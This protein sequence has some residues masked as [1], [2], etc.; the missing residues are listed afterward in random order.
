M[1]RA[2]V[3]IP[4]Y[5]AAATIRACL[6]ALSHQT[7]PV[8]EY[9]IIVVDDGSSD[10]TAQIAEQVEGVQVVRME[11]R[12]AAAARNRGAAAASGEILLFTDADCAPASD[13]AAT[14]LAPF[15]DLAKNIVGAK[16]AYRTAQRERVA[17]FVQLEYEE[18]YARLRRY[19]LIDFIDTYSAAYRRAIFL[20]N[21]GFDESFPAASVEDQEFSFRLAR[22]GYRMVFVPQAVVEHRHPASLWAYA[23]R[24]FRIGYWKVR[25]HRRFP[26]KAWQDTHTPI[27]LKLQVALLLTALPLSLIA[28]V[29]PLT[30]IGVVLLELAFGLSVLPLTLFIA[31]RDRAVAVIAPL[32]IFVRAAALGTGL[33]AGICGEFLP[34]ARLK[35]GLD[36]SWRALRAWK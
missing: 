2:S 31:R 5:N 6:D 13:W 17:R 15:A 33:V 12:G 11:H 1:V 3:V 27:T 30:W 21:R 24:K 20:E 8:N 22:Q 25:V 14:L 9:N 7:L 4:A 32:M 28:L 29:F 34:S 16:G 36:I 26:E 10:A 35:R 23:R 19:A 18:K